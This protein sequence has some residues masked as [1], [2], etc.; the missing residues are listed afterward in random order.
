MAKTECFISDKLKQ[1]MK[2]LL[3]F[4]NQIVCEVKEFYTAPLVE[5]KREIKG[6]IYLVGGGAG[7]D[8]NK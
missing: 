8:L 5:K 3:G 4:G 6:E 7:V 2:F 1:M